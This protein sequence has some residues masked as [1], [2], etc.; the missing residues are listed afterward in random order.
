MRQS[1]GSTLLVTTTSP[2]GPSAMSG[3]Q[4]NGGA[5]HVHPG[6][7]TFPTFAR[8]RELHRD[9]IAPQRVDPAATVSERNGG[10]SCPRRGD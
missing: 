9:P 3:G 6:S 5:A 7:A 10:A 4:A 1:V 8:V 2:C